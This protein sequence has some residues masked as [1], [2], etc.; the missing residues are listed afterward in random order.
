MKVTEKLDHLSSQEKSLSSEHAVVQSVIDYTEQ[1][2][3]HSTDDEIMCMYDNIQSR[4]DR[5]MK[6][7]QK[8]GRSLEPVEEVDIGVEV[9]RTEDLSQ[10]F[11]TKSK[12]IQ[13]PIKFDL[14]E[15]AAAE[16]K[17]MSELSLITN[18]E[19]MKQKC[20]VKLKSLQDGSIIKCNI[21]LIKG[22][23][24]RIRYTLTE[25]GNKDVVVLDNKGKRIRNLRASSHD[26]DIN[27]PTGLAVDDADN[28]YIHR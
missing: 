26:I 20:A 6:E 11:Q 2:M 14:K 9:S 18:G 1:C 19:S 16:V 17:K 10:L 12:I 25:D 15:K 27:I 21:D 28:N 7:Y 23:E 3:E 4:I 24:Y 22:N 5:E 13:L 8:E